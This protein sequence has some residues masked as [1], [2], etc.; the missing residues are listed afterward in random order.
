MV[1]IS[2]DE[3]VRQFVSRSL[4][5]LY[6]V[7]GAY[8]NG[9]DVY[10]TTQ[11]INSLLCL[12][13]LPNE[14]DLERIPETHLNELHEWPEI[15]IQKSCTTLRDLVKNFRHAIAHFNI[16]L[17]GQDE[18]EAVRFENFY[19]GNLRWEQTFKIDELRQVAYLLH[20]TIL[21]HF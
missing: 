4:T 18:I 17:I 19:K 16:H 2:E 20:Q 13:V 1:M 14:H 11:L 7:E 5:N 3:L 21:K 6:F 10:E 12:V 9:E 8:C 15:R